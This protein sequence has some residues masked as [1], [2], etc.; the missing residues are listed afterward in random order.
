MSLETIGS[1]VYPNVSL[2]LFLNVLL[3]SSTVVFFFSS[4]TR[5]I[6]EP[7]GTGTLIAPPCN[8][9]SRLGI[10]FPMALAAPVDVGII[11]AA[12]ALPL[13]DLIPLGCVTSKIT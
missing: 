6:T 4:N 13:L 9:P 1:S 5:S 3:I 8:L 7:V 2:A 12:A 11:F 10:T